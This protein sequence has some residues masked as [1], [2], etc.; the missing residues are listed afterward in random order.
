MIHIG[1]NT[2]LDHRV[3]GHQRRPQRQHLSRPGP[4]LPGAENV[5]NFTQ[6]DS[7]L[8]GDQCGAHTV[9]YIEVKN[10]TATDRA[11]GDHRPRSATTSC[12]TPCSAA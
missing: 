4:V 12:S 3:Q 1:K 11:R 7:L 8:L 9:P 5:R 6:C 2:P 10:P